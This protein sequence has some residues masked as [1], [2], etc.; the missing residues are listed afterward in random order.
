MSQSEKS[1]LYQELKRAGVKFEKEYRKYTTDELKAG[2]NLLRS[3]T[4]RPSV[5]EEMATKPVAPSYEQPT[6]EFTPPQPEQRYTPPAPQQVRSELATEFRAPDTEAGIRQN[7]RDGGRLDAEG[8]IW[9]QD[10]IRKPSVPKARAR[11]VLKYIDPGVTQKTITDGNFLETFEV[12]GTAS[13]QSEVKITL[14]SYQVGL[15]RDPRFP[16]RIHIYNGV[17]G[18]DFFDVQEY[19]GGPELVP[20]ECKRMYVENVLCYDI[21]TVVR[22]IETEA[23]RLGLT[24]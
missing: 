20:D 3:R 21:R 19:Y 17:R 6:F 12:A 7:T 10:E 18:F 24:N 1:A 16:F 13:V 11:R 9:Y 14:P 5:E 15:Y 2:V 23:R 8:L 4:G 22:A